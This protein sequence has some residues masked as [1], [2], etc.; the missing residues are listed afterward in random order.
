MD[1][2]DSILVLFVEGGYDTEDECAQTDEALLLEAQDVFVDKVEEFFLDLEVSGLVE[3]VELADEETHVLA[4]DSRLLG[5]FQ[6][7][8]GS[9]ALLVIRLFRLAWMRFVNTLEI[10]LQ[11]NE[12]WLEILFKMAIN[13][14][15]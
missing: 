11:K 12:T 13:Q 7:F 6:N 15:D 1:L 2:H 10:V 8:P 5:L 4:E 14:N 3:V 9:R